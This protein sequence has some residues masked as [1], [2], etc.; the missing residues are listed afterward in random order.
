MVGLPC[1]LRGQVITEFP[2]LT[3]DSFPTAITAGPD[4]ALWFTEQSEPA[5]QIGRITTDGVVTEFFVPTFLCSPMG[6]A[7]GSDGNLWFTENLGRKIGRITPSGSISEFAL[8]SGGNPNLIAAGPDG[9]LWFTDGTLNAVGKITTAGVITEYPV[10]TFNSFPSY[11]TAGPDGNVWFTENGASE[12]GRITPD[13]V[14]TIFPLPTPTALPRGI[15]TGPDG[16][17]WFIEVGG[18]NGIERMTPAGVVTG[19][20]PF[21]TPALDASD[22]VAGPDGNLWFTEITTNSIGRITTGGLITAFPIPAPSSWPLGIAAG[23]DGNLWFAQAHAG[24]IGRLTTPFATPLG[25]GTDFHPAP[26]TS[27][28]I[29]GVL[30]PGESVQ[31][32]PVWKKTRGSPQL[33]TGIATGFTGPAGPTYTIDVATADYGTVSTG[34]TVDCDSTT[35]D[36]FRMTVTGARPAAH[37]D[38]TFTETLNFSAVFNTWTI[39]IGN[40]FSDVLASHQFYF[41]VETL[42]HSGVTGGCGAGVFCPDAFVTRAQ[43]PVFLLKARLGPGFLPIPATGTVFNDVH[44]GDFAASWIEQLA[45]FHITGGCG[46][47][48]Y[49]PDAFVTRAQMA[50]FILK[51]KHGSTYLPPSCMQVFDDVACPGPFADWIE[52]LFTEGITGGCGGANYCPDASST[53]GQMAVFLDRMMGLPEPPPPTSTPAPTPLPPTPTNTPTTQP[54]LT[55]TPTAIP[56]TVTPPPTWTPVTTTPTPPPTVTPIT[57]TVTPSMT[58]TGGQC[59]VNCISPTPTRTP[60][61]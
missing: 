37:W 26:L 43:M 6:I 25:L 61:P 3:P 11:I 12:I 8:P 2:P 27:S 46:G 22:I 10:P 35:G 29:N 49:C 45:T 23:G 33:L 42:F 9:N 17:L 56:P 60:T 51:T 1:V 59:L 38:A 15:A 5:N 36:C 41:F 34:A 18:A 48:N 16:N 40:S 52:Q 54:T 39:H 21:S 58:G 14:I 7:A 55:R 32:A 57:F 4:G 53:R 44:V 19:T 28:N 50:V 47:G 13:G 31:V 24:L 20:F 30:E